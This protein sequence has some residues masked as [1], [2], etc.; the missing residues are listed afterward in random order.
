MYLSIEETAEFIQ[1]PVSYVESLIQ[2]GKI[3]A[4]MMGKII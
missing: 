2:Q 4:S 3:R 1:L